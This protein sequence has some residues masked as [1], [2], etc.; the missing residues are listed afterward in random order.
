[1]VVFKQENFEVE[2]PKFEIEN[3]EIPVLVDFFASWCGPCKM[4]SPII[5]NISEKYAGKLRVIKVD[6]DKHADFAN[7]YEIRSIPTLLFFKEG[8]LV[9]TEV[10]FKPE[11]QLC[12]IIEEK[13]MI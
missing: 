4:L 10:G 8:K 2:N 9:G 11:K 7:E 5:K 12:N 13:L 1:M 6:I 3:S